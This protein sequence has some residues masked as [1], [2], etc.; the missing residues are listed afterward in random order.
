MFKSPNAL[1]IKAALPGNS[2]I[3]RVPGNTQI[4]LASPGTV[5]I[6]S[7]RK[8]HSLMKK[9]AHSLISQCSGLPIKHFIYLI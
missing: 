8:A 7:E 5:A 9:Q 3:K 2:Q 4:K 6:F 1:Y